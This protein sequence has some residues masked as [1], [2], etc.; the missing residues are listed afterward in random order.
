MAVITDNDFGLAGGLDHKNALAETKAEN[1]A[2]YFLPITK[3]KT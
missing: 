3:P 1:P 2:L